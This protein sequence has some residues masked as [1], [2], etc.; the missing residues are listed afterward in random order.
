MDRRLSLVPML[1]VGMPTAT[2]CVVL[3]GGRGRGAA[4]TA[5]PRRTVGT[6]ESLGKLWV[7]HNG[8]PWER[9]KTR[10]KV[11]LIHGRRI[12]PANRRADQAGVPTSNGDRRS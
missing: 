10:P 4:K 1:R 11:P 12:P 8:G 3:L 2:L 9:G 7:M 6:R 5:F